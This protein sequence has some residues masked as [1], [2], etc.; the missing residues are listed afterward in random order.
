MLIDG[1]W[2]ADWH[3]Y[4]KSDE[5]GRFVR[6]VSSFRTWITRDGDPGPEGQPAVKAEPDRF[7][8]F[9]NYICP[10]AGRTLIVRK[11]KKLEKLISV[12]VLEPVMSPQGWR[13]GDFPG[14]S[15]VDLEIGATYLHEIYT[16]A[17][18]GFTGRASVPV[19][20]DKKD[21][22][23]IN[24]ESADI[25][26]IFDTAFQD[27]TGEEPSLRPRAIGRDVQ[28]LNEHIY[29][30]FN[31]GVYRAGFARSQSA[32]E[33]AVSDIFKTLDALDQRLADGRLYLFGNQLTDADVRFYVTLVRF[34]VAYVDLFKCNL[35][36]VRE[37][38]N[39]LRYLRR[40][41]ALP[42]FDDSTFFDH[43]KAGY[44]SIK[45]LNPNG[46]V[47]LGPDLGYLEKS[48]ELPQQALGTRQGQG[49]KSSA[50]N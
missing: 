49:Q 40:L 1:K 38:Q 36:T 50:L 29:E 44:Y 21:K 35:R 45:A 23:I 20:W 6:Q 18:P 7:H 32:Y 42:A 9:V 33:E 8:L 43:I 5:S 48:S 31:N 16:R 19:L 13:F 39:L 28:K 10:W 15:G 37:Y 25:I 27:F 11:L 24:N 46:I 14:A 34:D 30:T 47:P 41:Y 22:R 17:D 26:R 4:Q 12:S 2:S 3:P